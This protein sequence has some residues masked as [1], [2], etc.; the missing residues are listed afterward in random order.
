MI[1]FCTTC[2]GRTQHLEL[3]LAQNIRDNPEQ[4]AKFIVLDYNSEDSLAD[5]I[6]NNF[7]EELH[8]GKLIF[9][10][11]KEQTSFKMA[12]AKNMAHRLGILEGAEILV[13]LDADNYTGKGF[14]NFIK[15]KFDE[16]GNEI[17]LWA[18]MIKKGENR[19]PRGISGRIVVS[20]NAFLNVGGYDE[21]YNTYSPDD[22]DF[23]A[24]LA[25]VGYN[26]IQIENEYLRAILHNDKMR[27]REYR[28]VQ[29]NI[30]EDDFKINQNSRV[31][32]YGNI[33]L[34]TVYK[35]FTDIPI[36]LKKI[37]TRIFNIGL[38]KTATN[39]FHC[40]MQILGFSSGHWKNAHWAKKIWQD[41]TE[42]GTSITLEKNYALSDLPIPVIYRELD[43]GYPN[44]KFI[45]T[46][47]DENNWIESIK[48]HWNPEY[49]KFKNN[50]NHDPF[51][52]KIHKI[53][54]GQKGFDQQIFLERY[55]KYNK[56]VID[57]FKD[58]NE[59][60][61]ILNMDN[62][63]ENHWI[64]LCNFLNMEIPNLEYPKE[65]ES[66]K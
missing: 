55:R 62:K 65:Y 66:I 11:F 37:P 12:H 51:S 7:Q 44:S 53:L 23:N 40:A 41:M 52:H 24:R 14:A 61:L 25:R 63:E 34:G 56:E 60:F 42:I 26:G 30:D 3:T 18:K 2:K 57:Y 16:Y 9:Y 15:N 6:Q 64:A 20:K 59:D 8:S 38:H 48:K 27:F 39:S 13:N 35:N 19:L 17:Y 31:V 47:R 32:N 36:E 22:K 46:I 5:F 45:L 33:G 21:K 50:W 10:Q 28:H 54:Y 1:V 43:K 4:Y 49:N 29:N 58:R